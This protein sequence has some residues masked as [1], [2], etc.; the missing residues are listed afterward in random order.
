MCKQEYHRL[1]VPRKGPDIGLMDGTPTIVHQ[2]ISLLSNTGGR[3]IFAAY[4]KAC[5]QFKIL[6]HF[7]V[8]NVFLD[9]KLMDSHECFMFMDFLL[10]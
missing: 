6:S 3:L 8:N 4:K 5:I 9:L 10:T 1:S 2:H 7:H